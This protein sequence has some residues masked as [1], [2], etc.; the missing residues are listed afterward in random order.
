MKKRCNWNESGPLMPVP[1]VTEPAFI[2]VLEVDNDYNVRLV[3]EKESE[4]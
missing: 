2:Y 1:V 3:E 4:E